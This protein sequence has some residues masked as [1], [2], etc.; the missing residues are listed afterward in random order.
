MNRRDFFLGVVAVVILTLPAL[1]LMF[2]SGLYPSHDGLYHIARISQFYQSLQSGQFPVVLAPT[3]AGSLGYPLF[4]VNYQLPYYAA[5]F[6]MFIKSDPIFAYKATMSS[7]FILSSVFAFFLFRLNSSN[8]ASLTGA[9]IFTYL[10][11]RFAN[12]Y[13]RGSLGESVAIM[14]L[15]L[16][17]FA[18][19]R[20]G[21]TSSKVVLIALSVFGFITSHTAVFIILLPFTLA[22]IMLLVRPSKEALKKII[23]GIAL[24]FLLSAFQLLPSVYEKKFLKFDQNLIGLYKGHFVNILQLLRIPAN[25]I[26]LGTP[27]QVGITTSFVFLMSFFTFFRN[28][29][30]HIVFFLISIILALFM[31]QRISEFLWQ[32]LPMLSYVL[33]PWRF[34]SII[35]ISSAFLSCLLIDKFKRKIILSMF[36]ILLTI[37]ASRHYFLKPSIK[38]HNYP[39][40]NLTTQNEFD[41]IWVNQSTFQT[42]DLVTYDTP[43]VI[44]DVTNKPFEITFKIKTE[45]KTNV[46]ISRLYFPGWSVKVDTKRHPVLESNGLVSFQIPKGIWNVKIY[47]SQTI[48]RKIANFL[49][50]LAFLLLIVL[51]RNSR[52]LSK[53]RSWNKR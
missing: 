37:Y 49:T 30:R 25:D 45:N 24:G 44:S 39:T 22:F 12:L 15:P 8:I 20:K 27:F 28:R 19:S 23:L 2:K 26:N 4:G 5:T 32:R 13:T 52:E 48:T 10:P 38:G 46:A 31:T 33:Y 11:Y 34:L 47:F 1:F 21:I 53:K 9:L 14:F 17:L 6:F 7:T 35:V 50:V 36:L 18:V 3:A 51:I 41:P 40:A 16:L 43:S 29:N 42:R